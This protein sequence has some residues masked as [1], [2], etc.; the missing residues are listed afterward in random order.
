[1]R[2]EFIVYLLPPFLIISF[3]LLFHF[4]VSIHGNKEGYLLGMIGYWLVGCLVPV[5]LWISETNRK[6][7]LQFRSVN[8]W[9]IILLLAP[10]ALAIFFGPFK[11]RIGEATVLI[12]ILSLPY[13][14]INAFCEECLWRGLFFVH[15]QGNYFHAVVVPS[16]W[17]GIWHYVPLSV[18]PASV[19]NLYFI[20]SATG[21]G[22][23]WATLT[24]YTRSVFW[25]IL[26]HTLVD[27]TGI[28]L[29]HYFR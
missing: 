2:G 24:Y 20:L 13:A 27:F 23:C 10:V 11:Q 22:L 25:S 21:L 26:S 17:F 12:I 5:F 15:H 7:L 14:F 6:L 19:G 29:L 4:L 28:G 3:Y 9:Q 16:V 1:M 8:W 18:Q